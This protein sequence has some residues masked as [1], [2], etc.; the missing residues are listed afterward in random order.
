MQ[1]QTHDSGVLAY[2]NTSHRSGG[3]HKDKNSQNCGGVMWIHK[4]GCNELHKNCL[5]IITRWYQLEDRQTEFCS[6]IIQ[7]TTQTIYYL[8]LWTY[9]HVHTSGFQLMP[10]LNWPAWYNDCKNWEQW[11]YVHCCGWITYS[12]YWIL[13]LQLELRILNSTI[14]LHSIIGLRDHITQ[15][16]YRLRYKITKS[17]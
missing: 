12:W 13:S 14:K 9:I 15:H 6:E 2:K 10:E 11:Q 4:I 16:N 7:E 17:N 8:L 1:L 5:S 3:F